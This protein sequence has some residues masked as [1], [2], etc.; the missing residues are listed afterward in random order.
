MWFITLP[1][2]VGPSTPERLPEFNNLTRALDP[3]LNQPGLQEDDCPAG[4]RGEL[5]VLCFSSCFLRRVEVVLTPQPGA[6][7]RR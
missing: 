4:S 2:N 7:G 3:G 1:P 6:E 5:T